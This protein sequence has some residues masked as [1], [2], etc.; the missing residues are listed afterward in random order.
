MMEKRVD[1]LVASAQDV[2]RAVELTSVIVSAL[3]RHSSDTAVH[4][5]ALAWAVSRMAHYTGMSR[6]K[7]KDLID[8]GWDYSVDFDRREKAG[9]S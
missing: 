5:V 8:A 9:M 2:E 3:D 7:L 1:K 4:L 6:D